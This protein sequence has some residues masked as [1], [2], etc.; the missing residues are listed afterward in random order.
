MIFEYDKNKSKS[1]KI[2][3]NIDFLEI[4]KLWQDKQ[5]IELVASFDDEDRYLNI[6]KIDNKIW[7]VITTY[8]NNK[9]RIISAR[10]ARK[11]EIALY[12]SK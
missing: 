10:R 9:I 2:K 7:A 3:H 11:K 12:E 1:N 6:G 5:M 8:R 4:Q